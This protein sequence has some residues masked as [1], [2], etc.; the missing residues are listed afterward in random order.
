[1]VQGYV[2]PGLKHAVHGDAQLAHRHDEEEYR[3]Q[4]V[5]CQRDRRE[6]I[7]A[8]SEIERAIAARHL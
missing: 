5:D 6:Q 2:Q 3:D 7:D 8:L 1:M 4:L